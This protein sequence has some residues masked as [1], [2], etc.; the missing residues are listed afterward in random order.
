MA[1]GAGAVTAA[2]AVT[3][4]APDSGAGAVTNSGAVAASGAATVAAV[5]AGGTAEAPPADGG[6]PCRTKKQTIDTTAMMA[7][8]ITVNFW[9]FLMAAKTLMNILC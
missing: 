2:D 6:V 5:G 7:S 3:D 8:A 4:P 9:D 1:A